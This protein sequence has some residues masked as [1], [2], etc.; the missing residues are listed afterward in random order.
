MISAEDVYSVF[1]TFISPEDN[2]AADRALSLCSSSLER[3]MKMLR[4]DADTDD[5]RLKF[6]AA[7]E[8]YYSYALS[9]MADIEENADFRAGDVT[10]KR[11]IKETLEIAEKIRQ[12]GRDSIS[13]LLKDYS[14]GA[15]SV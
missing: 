12:D 7:C 1:L 3:L 14:F 8:A 9:Q 2:E 4:D 5:S 10:V 13:G 15:W 11:R 6:A